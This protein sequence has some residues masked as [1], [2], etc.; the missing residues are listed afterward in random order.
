MRTRQGHSCFYSWPRWTVL[1]SGQTCCTSWLNSQSRS[2]GLTMYQSKVNKL[3][4][5]WVSKHLVWCY[6]WFS[7]A[8]C[9]CFLCLLWK[10]TCTNTVLQQ[11]SLVFICICCMLTLTET[12]PCQAV[13]EYVSWS[14]APGTNRRD[15]EYTGLVINILITKVYVLPKKKLFGIVQILCV[16]E[17][18]KWPK[19]KDDNA[20]EW[21][22][23]VT[24]NQT[25]RA[26]VLTLKSSSIQI[27]CTSKAVWVSYTHS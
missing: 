4:N 1:Y 17:C 20:E 21:K 14:R 18:L 2:F 22:S 27:I 11:W 13:L 3:W 15:E 8:L 16:S 6:G 10:A 24:S 9:L 7:A 5:K 26:W 12:K 25:A 19:E 23:F